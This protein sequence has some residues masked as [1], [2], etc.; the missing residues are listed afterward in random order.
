MD[1]SSRERLEVKFSVGSFQSFLSDCQTIVVYFKQK[2]QP[3]SGVLL[4]CDGLLYSYLCLSNSAWLKSLQ[5]RQD[6][7]C[8]D[9]IVRRTSCVPLWV[10]RI[11]QP[12]KGWLSTNAH[13]GSTSDVLAYR[14]K[15]EIS[16]CCVMIQDVTATKFKSYSKKMSRSTNCFDKLIHK[17][18]QLLTL[19]LRCYKLNCLNFF[20]WPQKLPNC[21]T[22]IRLHNV[23]WKVNWFSTKK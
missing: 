4:I 14:V 2:W 12:Y 17:K 7:H 21:L 16:C 3:S 11:S 18:S 5:P 13:R 9:R 8:W 1:R 19:N 6:E 20:P 23:T 22:V 15:S 10:K